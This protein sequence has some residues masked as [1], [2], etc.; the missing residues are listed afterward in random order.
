MAV[1]LFP[2]TCC[3]VKTKGD[4]MTRPG[5]QIVDSKDL[6]TKII[7]WNFSSDTLVQ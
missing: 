6:S 4:R 3:F 5:T 7:T 2:A 1:Y